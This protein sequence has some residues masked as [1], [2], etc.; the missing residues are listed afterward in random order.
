MCNLYVLIVDISRVGVSN[1]YVL[2]F[3]SKHLFML[4]KSKSMICWKYKAQVNFNSIAIM[5]THASVSS[6]SRTVSVENKDA[7]YFPF[8]T[9]QWSIILFIIWLDSV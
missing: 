9:N 1:R 7:G 8:K 4:A 6:N 3:L 2:I 5:C